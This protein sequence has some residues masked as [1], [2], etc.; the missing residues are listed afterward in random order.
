[1]RRTHRASPRMSAEDAEKLARVPSG[2]GERFDGYTIVG[3]RF[4]SGHVLALRRWAASSIGPAYT[5][6]WHQ[7]PD[8]AWRLYSTVSSAH[9]CARYIDSA[10]ALSW[11]GAI[12][13]CWADPHRLNVE[14]RGVGLE[15]EIDFRDS[16]FSRAFGATVG[17]IPAELLDA[18]PALRAVEWATNAY[19]GPGA[20]SLAGVMPNGNAYRLL[21]RE[22][23]L[24]ED[25]R[26][27]LNG[28]SLGPVEPAAGCARIGELAVPTSG[29]LAFATARFESAGVTD[30]RLLQG[31]DQQGAHH[32]SIRRADARTS[33][34]Y[35]SRSPVLTLPRIP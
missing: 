9:S 35:V 17:V 34:R 3:Q 25:A 27:W 20:L 23:W 14:V 32:T 4:Q 5:S 33:P 7:F 28:V 24:M 26:A 19:L 29:I 30:I 2:D 15:W 18:D 11:K 22:L 21:P 6:V 31:P 1:M 12:R 16:W 13:L 10:T 8:A